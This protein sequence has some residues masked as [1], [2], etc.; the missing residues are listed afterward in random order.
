MASLPLGW[1]D[2]NN[3]MSEHDMK[4]GGDAQNKFANKNAY[5]DVGGA[6]YQTSDEVKAFYMQKIEREVAAIE[7]AN[8]SSSNSTTAKATPTNSMPLGWENRQREK[9]AESMQMGA[10]SRNNNN[11]GPNASPSPS[12]SAQ[13]TANINGSSGAEAALVRVATHTLEAMAHSLENNPVALTV[14]ERAAFAA[15]M[16]KAMDAIS[17]CK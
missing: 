16:K 1:G 4:L 11:G 7:S 17:K 13:A 5:E 12:A 8:S 14:D 3:T 15:A 9:E 6:T 2:R 10:F